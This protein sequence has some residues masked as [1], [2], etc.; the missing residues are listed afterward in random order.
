M[1]K[2]DILPVYH[3]ITGSAGTGK[4]V[5][6]R[7]VH[8]TLLK[9]FSKQ[10]HLANPDSITVLLAAPTG[11]A[12]FNINGTTIHGALGITTNEN[13]S[14]EMKPLSDEI[15]N[16]YSVR[17]ENLKFMIIDEVSMV[18]NKMLYKIDQRL[19]EIKGN[20]NQNFGGVSILFFGD[21]NQLR[22]VKESYVFQ[23]LNTN[24][25]S[26]LAGNTLWSQ[27]KIYRLT[28]IMRQKDD[29]RFAKALNNLS[30]FKLTSD[31]R[32]LFENRIFSENN[33]DDNRTLDKIPENCIHLFTTN[34]EVD[35]HNNTVIQRS[36]EKGIKS[37][38]MDNFSADLSF[39]KRENLL[40][41]LPSLD[42]T[43]TQ[44]LPS[45]IVLETGIRYMITV[46]IDV[47][48]GLVNG[49]SGVLKKI[50]C[51]TN[52]TPLLLWFDFERQ[53][54]GIKARSSY[55]ISNQY[56]TPIERVSKSFY[57]KFDRQLF[58]IYRSQFPIRPSEAIT[59]H[60]SQ[61]QTYDQV[62]I[63]L[64]SRMTIGFYYTGLSR[65]KKSCGLYLIGEFNPP[66]SQSPGNEIVINEINRMEN[67]ASV[68]FATQFIKP[69]EKISL[70]FQ[71]YPYLHHHIQ[72]LICDHNVRNLDILIFVETRCNDQ[73]I[74]GFRLIHQIKYN[75][76]KHQS[77]PF[78]I[79][80]YRKPHL[81]TNF[82]AEHIYFNRD[83]T[84]HME[85]LIFDINNIRIFAIYVS[86]K[87]SHTSTKTFEM[88]NKLID[89][90]FNTIIVGDFNIDINSE[91]GSQ[92][93]QKFEDIGFHFDLD[94]NT[95]STDSSQIDLLFTNF[96][97]YNTI[98][99]ES[100]DTLHRPIIF[101]I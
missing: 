91:S 6:I 34:K 17:L 94:L 75:T 5:L 9:E 98:Y 37:Q 95:K 83:K 45:N 66:K 93:K 72:D 92:F 14:A 62:A 20:Y 48:D 40:K 10:K 15:K 97:I 1:V 53:D 64:T 50:D 18:G 35:N 7:S 87:Y 60:K 11:L 81:D 42:S 90:S 33:P 86:P 76:S 26:V 23:P 19:K 36:K 56:L 31:D 51:S 32:D 63:H 24:D 44:G 55:N 57:L 13:K 67:E 21:F 99:Y 89:G 59:I 80:V 58:N 29:L 4:S 39:G 52:E 73:T 16:K 12:A 28:E 54:I 84:G 3:L 100:I 69:S 41:R 77:R 68:L 101:F 85:I 49:T 96:D 78:G 46:N 27:F 43:E 25:L 70:Y 38:C 65:A 8:Q 88:L 71:N 22:P 47:S 61:G 82:V 2:N 74:D 30:Q 79:A